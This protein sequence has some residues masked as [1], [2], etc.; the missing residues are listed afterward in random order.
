M[1]GIDWNFE[2]L[3]YIKRTPQNRPSNELKGYH[4]NN[5]KIDSKH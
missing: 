3:N 4:L 1:R 2:I 5:I